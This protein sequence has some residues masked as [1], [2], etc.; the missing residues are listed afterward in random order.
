MN[1]G[2]RSQIVILHRLVWFECNK[3]SNLNI[4]NFPLPLHPYNFLCYISSSFIYL[5]FS[6]RKDYRQTRWS[7]HWTHSLCGVRASTSTLKM[8]CR[9]R[10]IASPSPPKSNPIIYFNYLLND[11][12]IRTFLFLY[13]LKCK[14]NNVFVLSVECCWVFF[15]FFTD[16]YLSLPLGIVCLPSDS[17]ELRKTLIHFVLFCTWRVCEVSW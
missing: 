7:S 3:C 5:F 6:F 1:T 12:W 4:T 16:Q 14:I 9:S 13:C 8:N 11:I 10:S 17:L 15:C 2:G